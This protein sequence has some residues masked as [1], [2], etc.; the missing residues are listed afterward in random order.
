MVWVS[1][2]MVATM[3]CTNDVWAQNGVGNITVAPGQSLTLNFKMF[4]INYGMPLTRD[5]VEFKG[6]SQHSAKHI[7][8]YADSKGYVD[9]NPVQVQ[10]AIWRKTTG[11]W[12]AAD[13][14]LAAEIFENGGN[15][16]AESEAGAVFLT[17][18]VKAGTVQISVTPVTPVNVPNS[19]VNWPWLGEGQLTV[20]NKSKQSVTL[21]ARDG[22][23]LS[24]PHQHMIGYVTGL[25][26]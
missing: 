17:D 15:F 23:E 5:P 20:T 19:P 8:A 6:R 1:A 11:K 9:S 7:L 24:E 16:P 14:A 2:A 18:A 3:A 21:R 13:H 26:K 25:A 12:Q 22:F 10:L 4:C